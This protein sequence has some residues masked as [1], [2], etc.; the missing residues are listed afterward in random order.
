MSSVQMKKVCFLGAAAVG[1]SSII[2]SYSGDELT[3]GYVSTLGVRI[4]RSVVTLNE[5][6]REF[7]VWDIKGESGFYTIP[8]VYLAGSDGIML[9]ADGTRRATVDNALDIH[10]RIMEDFGHIPLV[11]L[12]NKTDLGDI[13]E[14][15]DAVISRL[16]ARIPDIYTCSAR[17]ATTIRAA[18]QS[19][20]RA[21]WGVK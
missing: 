10:A 21:M 13:W 15:D 17:S 6:L 9:V 1:K 4:T 20:G 12:I 18:M 8:E 16:R 7:V 14:I 2:A 19:L 5:R 11:M 3:G